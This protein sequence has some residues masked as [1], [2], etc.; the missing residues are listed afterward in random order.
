MTS[1]STWRETAEGKDKVAHCISNSVKISDSVNYF[2]GELTSICVHE[3]RCLCKKRKRKKKKVERWC[4]LDV[5]ES[6]ARAYSHQ[7]V[8]SLQAKL[9]VPKGNGSM[10]I[11]ASGWLGL[12][13]NVFTV[14]RVVQKQ[15]GVR[16]AVGKGCLQSGALEQELAGFFLFFLK[17]TL[18]LQ[19]PFCRRKERSPYLLF[20]FFLKTLMEA[21]SRSSRWNVYKSM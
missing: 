16:C 20:Y 12:R 17:M 19:N 15:S 7:W 21:H 3:L 1:S 2:D 18:P 9:C 5:H 11:G 10:N 14:A 13:G 6:A 8:T 4:F